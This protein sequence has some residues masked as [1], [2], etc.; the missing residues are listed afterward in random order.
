[1]IKPEL[2]SSAHRPSKPSAASELKFLIV[3]DHPFF[4]EGLQAWIERQPGWRCIGVADTLTSARKLLMDRQP[5]VVLLD[6]KLQNEDGLSLL[7]DASDLSR[8][9]ACIVLTQSDEVLH[10]ERAL[11]A[12]ARGFI[13]KEEA[14]DRVRAAVQLVLNNE[15]YV[16]ERLAARFVRRFARDDAAPSDPLHSLSAREL[17]VL[18]LLGSGQNIKEIADTLDIS[19]KTAEAHRDNL[20]RKLKLSDATTL[21]RNATIW[22]HEGRI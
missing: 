21:V 3:D 18:A 5:D 2:S 9:A 4:R 14:A 15:I 6:L 11:R 19:R 20:R 13:M 7:K 16:S 8:R 10:A 12:G 1:M 22:R 17:Q